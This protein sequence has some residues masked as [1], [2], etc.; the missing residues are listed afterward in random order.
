MRRPALAVSL[1]LAPLALVCALGFWGYTYDDGYITY[2]YARNLAEGRGLVYNPGERV[3]GTSA[4]GYAAL[5]GALAA[6]GRPL[7]LGVEDAGS[8]LF[9]AS[10]VGLAALLARRGA[11][12]APA[13]FGSLA[14]ISRFDLELEGC[15][16]LPALT[17]LVAAFRLSW[18]REWPV[19][20]GLLGALAASF[21]LDSGLALA[22]LGLL[23]WWRSRRFP[24]RFALAGL[25]GLAAVAL[26]LT[27][28]YGSFVPATLAA[29]RAELALAAPGYG[30]AQWAWLGR[31]YGEA[32]ALALLALAGAGVA[33][34]W[35][36]WRGERPALAAAAGWLAAH[37]LFYRAVGVPFSPWYHVHLFHAL[38]ALAVFGALALGGRAL[39]LAAGGAMAPRA[40]LAALLLL[41]LLLPSFRFVTTGWREPPDPRVRLYRDVA[42]AADRCAAHGGPIAA[43]EIG[44]LGFA[45]ERPVLDLVGLVDPGLRR[46]RVAGELAAAALARRPDF[47]VDHPTFAEP[48]WSPILDTGEVRERFRTVGWF[49][50]PEYPLTVR[51]LA[52]R[53]VCAEPAVAP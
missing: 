25:A 6:A 18:D 40:A 1:L 31:I 22:A 21:R 10:L 32:G 34:G 49:Q 29:K 9:F 4:P 17:L 47:L 51:L 26:A 38:L 37:E 16:T 53:G 24:W 7:G 42:R 28:Y 15:E 48:Y 13:L 39:A 8:A 41:P 35:S 36:R 12:L 3:L 30:A 45:T 23:L 50:R 14:L 20:A 27:A 19:A 44:A 2:R 33:L 11:V 46:A 5:L 52:R 43:V